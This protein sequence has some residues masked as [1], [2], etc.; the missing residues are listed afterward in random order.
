MNS[1]FSISFR[2]ASIRAKVM[3]SDFTNMGD[4]IS[5]VSNAKYLFSN[6]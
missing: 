6:G 3:L 5:H 2:V 1:T 4:L